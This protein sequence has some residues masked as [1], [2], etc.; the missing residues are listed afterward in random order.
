[1][2]SNF[3][4]E[5]FLK[6]LE[7]L[8]VKTTLDIVYLISKLNKEDRSIVLNDS[9]IKSMLSVGIFN[10]CKKDFY[11]G[12]ERILEYLKPSELLGLYNV[13]DLRDLFS[14]EY[15]RREYIIF[16]SCI[17][18][19]VNDTV[20]YVLQNEELFKEFFSLSDYFNS[21]FVGL[22]YELL[23]QIIFKMERM[24]Y[25]FPKD[26]LSSVGDDNLLNII[27]E[28]IKEET[29][30]T[31]LRYASFK[32]KN[33]F[34]KNDIR[35]RYLFENFNIKTLA[36]NGITFDINILRKKEFFEK[37]K[38][39][40]LIEFRDVINKLE[41]KNEVNIIERRLNEYYDELLS[42]YDS[43]NDM[44][45]E[46][47]ELLNNP[48]YCQRNNT[49]YIFDNNV[50]LL[51]HNHLK[52]N[53]EN[54]TYYYENIDELKNEL[55]KETS[56]KLSEII[57]DI[58]FQDNIYNVWLNIKEMLR[59]NEKLENKV[60][61]DEWKNFY[62]II[63]NF[64]N[65]SNKQK[66]E[67]LREMRSK[68]I[69]VKFYDDLRKLKDVSYD[70]IKEDLFNLSKDKI[71]KDDNLSKVYDV[72]VYDLRNK[73]FNLLVRSQKP[74]QE[75]TH[76]SRWCYSIISNENSDV[77]GH[78]YS[79]VTFYYGYNTFENDR[80]ISAL[81][82]DSFSG[83]NKEDFTTKYVN[84]IMT[85][86]ELVTNSSWY[87]ELNIVN[88]QKTRDT[89]ESKRPDYLV[90]FSQIEPRHIEE[91]KRLNIPIVLIEL[92]KL[93]T[94]KHQEYIIP[95]DKEYDIY[96]SDIYDEKLLESRR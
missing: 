53:Y 82:Q 21:L 54:E 33:E 10:E 52:F 6:N 15:K 49:S 83:D 14:K 88:L 71:E 13:Q 25:A 31:I 60:I 39:N 65:I 69:N 50:W 26:F 79:D 66:M 36:L 76:V 2:D 70:L 86:E 41:R 16:A 37:L 12:F 29:L 43:D 48:Q 75:E 23:K 19:D 90:V 17:G 94:K 27:H 51:F 9:R 7:M 34:F 89:Y 93:D 95:F 74:F 3:S 42:S 67:L 84:R 28:D 30:I 80:I 4:V 11:I 18:I 85:T 8:E 59:Y 1:M 64:D 63:L 35:A 92:R 24:D 55:K 81:E 20:K 40:S 57:I 68:N 72:P 96:V 47:I 22:D 32:V 87:S 38:S 77:F 44:F 62:N 91:A 46:Y 58:L 73:E 56:K 45:K 5:L 78:N 61:N